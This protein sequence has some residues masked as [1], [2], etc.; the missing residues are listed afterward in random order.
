M[1]CWDDV[2]MRSLGKGQHGQGLAEIGKDPV[3]S[4]GKRNLRRDHE[5]KYDGESDLGS[6]K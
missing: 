6:N 1:R 4:G 3:G 5:R 2:K